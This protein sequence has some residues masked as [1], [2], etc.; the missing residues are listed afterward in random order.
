VLSLFVGVFCHFSCA[1]APISTPENNL[2]IVNL[3]SGYSLLT[4]NEI[5]WIN[6]QK[7]IVHGVLK[8][9]EPFEYIDKNNTHLGLASEY[10]KIFSSQLGVKF[11]IVAVNHFHELVGMMQRGDIHT[12]SYLPKSEL[13]GIVFS[14]PVVQVPIVIY[15]RQ[16]APSV[17]GLS[18]L[19]NEDIAIEYPSRASALLPKAY[20]QTVFHVVSSPQEGIVAV[21]SGEVD[22]FVHNI[23]SIEY[24]RRKLGLEPLKIVSATPYSYDIRF[25]ANSNYAPIITI[26]D[27]I[28]ADLNE[29]EKRIIFDKWVNVTVASET[30]FMM[31]TLWGG[32]LLFIITLVFALV[33]SWNRQLQNT[34]ALRTKEIEGS[35]EEVRQLAH[36]LEQVREDEKA[37]LAREIHDGLGH[38]LTDLSMSIRSLIHRLAKEDLSAAV[39]AVLDQHLSGIKVLVREASGT[40]RKII[41][42][43]HPSILEDFGLFAAIEWLGQEFESLH[44]IACTVGGDIT[45]VSLS[46]EARITLFRIAQESLINAARHANAKRV[47]ITV[48]YDDCHI[49]LQ[50]VDDGD[51]LSASWGEKQH[52]FGI[53]GM[54]ERVQALKGTI[55][56]GNGELGGTKL[57]VSL[58]IQSD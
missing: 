50:T 29:R 16:D 45:P 35:R 26:I 31:I 10:V 37:E 18:A 33:L 43:L 53:K 24:Y 46:K 14:Q 39:S 40:S 6:N 36:H 48:S 4:E 41:C 8:D 30:D 5:A 58:P 44:G 54:R 28:V 38:T 7:V 1:G 51:G 22:V 11:K 34:V 55:S 3:P 23:F 42:D 21:L 57:S 49:T 13:S 32:A 56:F 12:A 19:I 20:P 17:T 52:S 15:G 27:K 25:S 47:S 2:N 9:H